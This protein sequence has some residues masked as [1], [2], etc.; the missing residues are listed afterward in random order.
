MIPQQLLLYDM[1][2]RAGQ[3]QKMKK[4]LFRYERTLGRRK[5][6][7]SSLLSGRFGKQK[8]NNNGKQQKGMRTDYGTSNIYLY[9]RP[10][11]PWS[12]SKQS[13]RS[14]RDDAMLPT[15]RYNNRH[16]YQMVRDRSLSIS[17]S[18]LHPSLSITA[19]ATQTPKL[20]AR[21][22]PPTPKS[23]HYRLEQ[24]EKMRKCR[25]KITENNQTKDEKG[26][27]KSQTETIIKWGI[28]SLPHSEVLQ[29]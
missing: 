23:K 17:P 3:H 19:Q 6:A 12:R 4:R 27:K 24:I 11:T 16:N 29:F 10:R 7:S 26:K 18:I 1:I 9:K 20:L 28:V 22:S 15:N 14:K 2:G 13:Q 5:P 8:T 21:Y 25:P